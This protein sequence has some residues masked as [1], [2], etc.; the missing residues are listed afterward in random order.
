LT[1]QDWFFR[2]D[3]YSILFEKVCD[4]PA[5]RRNYIEECVK[6][7]KPS[8]GYVYLANMM[9]NGFFNVAFTPNFDDLLNEACGTYAGCRPIVCAHDSSVSG[10]RITSARPKIIKLHGDFLYDSIKN[11]I[12]ETDVLE[13]NMRDK[14]MQFAKEYGLLVI[15]YGGR[16][17]SIMDPIETMLRS[18]GFFPHGLYWCVRKKDTQGRGFQNIVRRDNAYWVQIEGF[19][20]FMAELHEGL[21]LQL[22]DLLRDPYAATTSALNRF[23]VPADSTQHPIIRNH[24]TQLEKQV[25]NLGR[26]INT[27]LGREKMIPHAFLGAQEASR[28]HYTGALDQYQRALKQNPKN[29]EVIYH[30]GVTYLKIG[31]PERALRMAKSLIK[32]N[33]KGSP[34][35]YN[36]A[37]AALQHLDKPRDA[38]RF[39]NRS[40]KIRERGSQDWETIL[41]N[42][43]NAWLM[44]GKYKD[45]LAD[46]EKAI[47]VYGD[48]KKALDASEHSAVMN[49]CLT[50]KGLNR[51]DEAREIA[52]YFLQHVDRSTPRLSYLRASAHGVLGNKVEMLRELKRSIVKESSLIFEARSD[53]D[54]ADY[55]SDRNFRKLVRSKRR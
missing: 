43:S 33:P 40:L 37:S 2:D 52:Q 35:S 27:R 36:L 44:I 29:S 9:A 22:P 23:I 19:D 53:P 55:R 51:M 31:N 4:Q 34:E 3:E 28:R 49:Y 10:I 48:Y 47:R 26:N 39:L 45:A 20:E 38:I 54:F 21:G 7:A 1:K 14:F 18:P 5:Q 50:L 15:G 16:D 11:T 41:V 13:T 24:M 6:D 30:L 17:R 12:K 25:K 46:S 32:L 42:R 8:W